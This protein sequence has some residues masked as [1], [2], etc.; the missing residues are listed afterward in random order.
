[1]YVKF[2]KIFKVAGGEVTVLGEKLDTN[3]NLIKVYLV[4][5][6]PLTLYKHDGSLTEVVHQ[7]EIHKI[8]LGDAKRWFIDYERKISLHSAL[9]EEVKKLYPESVL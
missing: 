9:I 8:L 3:I 4:K 6:K 1:M 5:G 2:M 7:K